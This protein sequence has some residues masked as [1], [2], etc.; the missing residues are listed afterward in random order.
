M[1]I[2]TSVVHWQAL[3]DSPQFLQGFM[4]EIKQ[5]VEQVI[6]SFECLTLVVTAVTPDFDFSTPKRRS[7]T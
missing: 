2:T 4:N 3:D 5:D 6:H 7:S 1:H